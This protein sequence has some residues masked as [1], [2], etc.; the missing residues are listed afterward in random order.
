MPPVTTSVGREVRGSDR[1][2]PV[3]VSGLRALFTVA[4]RWGVFQLAR[5]FNAIFHL[6]HRICR[7][8]FRRLQTVPPGESIHWFPLS[9]ESLSTLASLASW[10][11]FHSEQV[12]GSVVDIPARSSDVVVYRPSRASGTPNP[13]LTRARDVRFSVFGRNPRAG[14]RIAGAHYARGVSTKTTVSTYGIP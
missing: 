3:K 10:I 2:I 7:L 14:A 4:I 6:R 9:L 11:G 8:C 5:G 13:H 12:Q 1:P